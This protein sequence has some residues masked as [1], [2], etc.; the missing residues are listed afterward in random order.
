MTVKGLEEVMEEQKKEFIKKVA[1][2][3]KKIA[4]E[5]EE[6]AETVIEKFYAHYPKPVRYRRQHALFHTH[7]RYYKNPHNTIF[8][9]GVELFPSDGVYTG[10]RNGQIVEVEP[11]WPSALAIFNGMHGNVEE[12][13]HAISNVPPRMSPTPWEL[14]EIKKLRIMD[15]IQSYF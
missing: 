5:L 8:H 13:P 11:D 1:C 7:K 12:F 9:V 10:H 2:V 14:L 6:E 4:D 15:N 3:A